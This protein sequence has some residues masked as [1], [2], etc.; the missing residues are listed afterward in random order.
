MNPLWLDDGSGPFR[1]PKLSDD[2][3]NTGLAR[4]QADN[5]AVLW[6]AAHDYEYAEISGSAVGLLTMGVSQGKP[7]CL[8]V[9]AWIQS[10]WLLYYSRKPFVTHEWDASLLDFASCGPCPHSVPELLSELGLGG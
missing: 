2:E 10:I 3:F 5:V 4:L 6:Q 8:S 9:M 1:N 7:M